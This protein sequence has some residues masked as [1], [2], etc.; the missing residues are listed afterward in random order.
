MVLFLLILQLVTVTKEMCGLRGAAKT[1]FASSVSKFTLQIT[2]ISKLV[3][4]VND[5]LHAMA[6]ADHLLEATSP[7]KLQVGRLQVRR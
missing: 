5:T 2:Y 3:G 7:G 4:K 1:E 6:L